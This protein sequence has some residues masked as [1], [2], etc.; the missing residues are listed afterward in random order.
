MR[1]ASPRLPSLLASQK[2]TQ[3]RQLQTIDEVALAVYEIVNYVGLVA[4]AGTPASI[5]G[6]INAATAEAVNA[7]EVRLSLLESG[8]APVVAP[9]EVFA[10]QMRTD[11]ERW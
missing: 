2:R 10:A 9:A 4:P 3:A 5:I 11:I 7:P 8:M 1:W 6:R